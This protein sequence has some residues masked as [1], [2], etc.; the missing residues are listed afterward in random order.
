MNRKFFDATSQ[1][2]PVT[3][4]M[5]VNARGQIVLSGTDSVASGEDGEDNNG[6]GGLVKWEKASEHAYRQAMYLTIGIG[7]VLLAV[8]LYFLL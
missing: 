2:P 8:R 4:C 6:V 5:P 1:S 7:T 3:T